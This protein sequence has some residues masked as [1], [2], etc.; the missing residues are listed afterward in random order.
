MPMPFHIYKGGSFYRRNKRYTLEKLSHIFVCPA[1]TCEYVMVAETE[2]GIVAIRDMHL[3]KCWP[4][5]LAKVRFE[6]TFVNAPEFVTRA[7]RNV[8][9]R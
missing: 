1:E 9:G 5:E 7:I 6:E 3:R 4:D 2:E 8:D